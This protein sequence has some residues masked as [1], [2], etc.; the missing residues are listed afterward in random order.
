M[1]IGILTV[2]GVFAG[3]VL[4]Y[5]SMSVLAPDIAHKAAVH[6]A[7]ARQDYENARVLREMA[8]H[9]RRLAAAQWDRVP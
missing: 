8:D 1:M 9:E 3:M 4:G 6:L 7:D 2:V 5:L